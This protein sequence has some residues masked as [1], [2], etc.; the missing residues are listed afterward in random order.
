MEALIHTMTKQSKLCDFLIQPSWHNASMVPNYGD[1]MKKDTR[2]WH[3]GF[4]LPQPE[5]DTCHSHPYWITWDS[6]YSFA[7]IYD[8]PSTLKSRNITLLTK[9]SIAKTMA[10]TVVM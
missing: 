6:Q 3:T 5:S 7:C 9:V 1:Q 8:Q 4:P 2:E 10:F